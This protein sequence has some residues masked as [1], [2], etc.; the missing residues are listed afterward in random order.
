M[1]FLL[2]WKGMGNMN[3]W[4]IITLVL[5]VI[6]FGIDYLLRK[7]KWKDNSKLEKIS[8]II[9]MCSGGPYVFLSALGMLLGI[10]PGC[11]K[12][13]FGEFIYK[14]TLIMS[15]FYFVV[16]IGATITSFILRKKGKTMASI[17]VNITALLY[18]IAVLSIN[19][20]IG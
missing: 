8:L 16:A 5:A 18:I 11:P 17:W 7:K 2:M 19:S 13:A 1:L 6:A 20:F 10:V 9:H 15:E 3:P 4:I 14:V 12:N